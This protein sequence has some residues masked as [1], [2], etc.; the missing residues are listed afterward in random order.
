MT[1]GR[2]FALLVVDVQNDFCPGGALAVRNG[3]AVVPPLNR[4]VEWTRAHGG[5]VYASRDWHVRDASHFKA[6]GGIW[7]VHCVQDTPGARFHPALRLPA[8]ATV[9][10]KGDSPAS[11]GYSAFEGHTPT[12]ASLV[13][14]LREKDIGHLYVGGL[15]TDYCVRHSVLDALKTGLQV[16]VLTDA[17]A[18]VDLNPGDSTRALEEMRAAGAGFATTEEVIRASN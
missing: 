4:V 9:V 17:V 18:G 5:A 2:A 8:D 14:D 16:T 6:N 7:P 3:D 12:G 13:H 10:T 15:A 1:D 11:D